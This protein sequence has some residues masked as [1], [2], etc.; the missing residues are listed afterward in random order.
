ME[1]RPKLIND[2]LISMR[3]WDSQYT[4][5]F[6]SKFIKLNC[7]KINFV[8]HEKSMMDFINSQDNKAIKSELINLLQKVTLENINS[9]DIPIIQNDLS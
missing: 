9:I 7:D 1:N 6:Y 5:L 2:I 4:R 3:H 8:L